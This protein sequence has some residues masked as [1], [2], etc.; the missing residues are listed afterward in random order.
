MERRWPWYVAGALFV[1][2]GVTAAAA[3]YLWWLPCR[4]Q[5][6]YGVHVAWTPESA[7]FTDACLRRMDEGTAFPGPG[8]GLREI[9]GLLL[10]TVATVVTTGVAWLVPVLC[11]RLRA[12]IRIALLLPGVVTVGLGVLVARSP[13]A[14][15]RDVTSETR[16]TELTTQLMWLLLLALMIAVPLAI[17]SRQTL[18]TVR[19][20]LAGGATAAFSTVGV[21]T[22][23]VLMGIWSEA[24]WDSPPGSGYPTAGW[25]MLCG[26]LI[27]VVTSKVGVSDGP[28]A[29][30]ATEQIEQV[31]PI[32]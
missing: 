5:M 19:W 8:Y 27:I 7:E 13:E 14:S 31:D 9:P 24:N 17:G 12:P 23:Y 18:D 28:S 25:L 30:T 3:T 6:M 21:I 1:V 11:Q 26:V 32:A 10:F 29:A 16:A 20:A 15:P 22:D 4:G 2:A